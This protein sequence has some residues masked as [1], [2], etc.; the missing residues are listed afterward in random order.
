MRMAERANY[1]K[2]CFQKHV[3]CK[4]ELARVELE[5]LSVTEN[6]GLHYD[7]PCAFVEYDTRALRDGQMRRMQYV[8]GQLVKV[9]NY[10]VSHMS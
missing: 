10:E 5:A 4:Q 1:G 7:R 8:L 3:W 9:A 2:L 6:P